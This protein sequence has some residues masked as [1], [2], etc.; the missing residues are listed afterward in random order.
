MTCF[1]QTS[2]CL[3]HMI[4]CMYSPTF[5]NLASHKWASS[6]RYNNIISCCFVSLCWLRVVICCGL[7]WQI[8]LPLNKDNKH[9]LLGEIDL[10]AWHLNLYDPKKWGY[11]PDYHVN[12]YRERVCEMLPYLLR[13]VR[14]FE[15]QKDISNSLEPFTISMANCPQQKTE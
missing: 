2:R 13:S 15:V 4:V 3:E 5:S 11:T 8:L 10:K 6:F 14:L 9:W 12:Y 1:D 7:L